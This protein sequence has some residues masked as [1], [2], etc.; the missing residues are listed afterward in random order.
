MVHFKLGSLAHKYCLEVNALS[1]LQVIKQI[2]IFFIVCWA[3]REHEICINLWFT[4]RHLNQNWKV[5]IVVKEVKTRLLF[6]FNFSEKSTPIHNIVFV[7]FVESHFCCH[8]IFDNFL[9]TAILKVFWPSSRNF[10]SLYVM[11]VK[12]VLIQHEVRSHV[13]VVAW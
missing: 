4:R 10:F 11:M 13:D 2:F 7:F 12:R 1:F 8:V 3:Y 9:A 5:V 6:R